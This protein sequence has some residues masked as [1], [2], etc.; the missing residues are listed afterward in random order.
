MAFELSAI[1]SEAE[2]VSWEGSTSLCGRPDAKA[3]Y[4]MRLQLGDET[5]RMGI[6]QQFFGKSAETVGT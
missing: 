6:K 2:Y 5:F 1:C 4:A 3:T